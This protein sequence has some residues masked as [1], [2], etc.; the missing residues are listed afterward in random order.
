MARGK[1]NLSLEEMLQA[2]IVQI[3]ETEEQLKS[4][5]SQKAELEAK[6]E[7]EEL[8]K[9]RDAIAAKGMTIEEAIAK[10]EA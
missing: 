2:V 10:L 8:K 9:L 3:S 7:E 6:I 1:K 4:L 5:K